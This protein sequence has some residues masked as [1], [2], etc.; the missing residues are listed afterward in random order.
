MITGGASRSLPARL[1]V[2]PSSNLA[3]VHV[4]S[5]VRKVAVAYLPIDGPASTDAPRQSSGQWATGSSC[6]HAVSEGFALGFNTA[7]LW[8]RSSSVW[9][10]GSQRDVEYAARKQATELASVQHT[11]IYRPGGETAVLL[12]VSCVIACRPSLHPPP[13]PP[14]FQVCN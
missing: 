5:V 6:G 2:P 14:C 4:N 11:F 8:T 10:Q 12:V 9:P 13:H 7:P 1:L 3:E